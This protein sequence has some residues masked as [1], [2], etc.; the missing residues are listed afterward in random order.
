M[1]DFEVRMSRREGSVYGGDPHRSAGAIQDPHFLSQHSAGPLGPTGPP[2]GP[3]P[4]AAHRPGF[5]GNSEPRSVSP[6][7]PA[8]RA[9]RASSGSLN[10]T[11]RILRNARVL[12]RVLTVR[13]RANTHYGRE[14]FRSLCCRI[15]GA[16]RKNGCHCLPELS[17]TADRIAI[18]I[19]NSFFGWCTGR[20]AAAGS[21]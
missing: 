4:V 5:L 6:V 10:R 12:G 1:E 13:V 19:G 21:F 20:T 11:A 8:G 2:V 16:C 17:R 15:Q 9:A 14:C 3:Q 18:P 7:R